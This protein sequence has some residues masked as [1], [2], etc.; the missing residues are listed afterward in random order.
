[1]TTVKDKSVPIS[2]LDLDLD[3]YRLDVS[4]S[5]QSEALE[6]LMESFGESIVGLARDIH[7]R[8]ELSPIDQMLVLP[9]DNRYVVLEGN[10]RLCAL[11][12]LNRPNLAPEKYRKVFERLSKKYTPI[13]RVQAK[14]IGNLHEAYEWIELKHKG[15][16]QGEGT[17]TW[18]PNAKR[19]FLARSQGKITYIQAIDSTL[20]K[21]YSDDAD[22]QEM[23]RS[24]R[25]GDHLT[26]LERILQDRFV[27]DQLGIEWSNGYLSFKYSPE[28][29]QPFFARVLSSITG[30]R[31]VNQASWSRAWA[32]AGDRKTW[33]CA[34][35]DV[36]PE[37]SNRLKEPITIKGEVPDRGE[38][39]ATDGKSPNRKPSTPKPKKEDSR[40]DT[41][42]FAPHDRYPLAVRELFN[43]IRD[44]DYST[45]PN[46]TLDSLRSLIEKTIKAYAQLQGDRV[47]GP[48]NQRSGKE[49]FAQFGH[50]ISWLQEHCKQYPS[51]K[52]H[53]TPISALTTKQTKWPRTADYFN[54]TNHND[55]FMAD[56]TMVLEAWN[57]F[58][59]VLQDLLNRGPE[60][61]PA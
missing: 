2:K 30:D 26:N 14:V 33:F 5:S 29:L 16:G 52:G 61:P 54:G 40:L 37:S 21:W 15:Q 28:D 19:N 55:Q 57:T 51:L 59:P 18:G 13:T 4:A 43:E 34:Q 44:V 9:V 31:G 12:L 35:D 17:V 7:Q 20:Q 58:H 32:T 48:E 45:I 27:K 47:R 41:R 23:L 36:L 22:F 46:M 25:H 1:M 24:I 42:G 56:K 6:L 8:G 60:A 10:R 53:L 39:P 3:N 49:G 50:C 38:R 11:R